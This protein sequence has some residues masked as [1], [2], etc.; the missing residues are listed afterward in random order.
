MTRRELREVELRAAEIVA[1]RAAADTLVGYPHMT[2]DEARGWTVG[3][4]DALNR[5]EMAPA[6]RMTRER[7]AGWLAGFAEITAE[8]AER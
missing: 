4:Y 1:D 7:L 3:Y 8:L 6:V 5:S 2:R